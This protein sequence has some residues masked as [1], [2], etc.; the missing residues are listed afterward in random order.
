MTHTNLRLAF[1]LCIAPVLAIAQHDMTA[2]WKSALI[3]LQR[4]V[5]SH[6]DSTGLHA[7]MEALRSSLEAFA[8]AHPEMALHIPAPLAVGASDASRQLEELSAAVDEVVR[9]TPGSPF[10][11]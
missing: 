6:A 1:A 2:E 4:R 8:A 7:D 11:L 9:R 3:D 10:N 5:A